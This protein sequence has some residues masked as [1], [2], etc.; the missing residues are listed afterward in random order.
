[1]QDLDVFVFVAVFQEM[2]GPF[3][4]LGLGAVGLVM[5]GFAWLVWRERTLRGARLARAEL[6]GL[7]GGAAAIL[8]MQAVT[9]SSFADI[10]G[11]IDW[12]LVALIFLAGGFITTLAAYVGFGLL[13]RRGEARRSAAD[14]VPL[15]AKGT[16]RAA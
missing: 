10:G 5:A 14:A 12:V 4:W 1:M 9:H 13:A 8:V 6:V 7:V 11:P 15:A 2:L 16:R 3:L